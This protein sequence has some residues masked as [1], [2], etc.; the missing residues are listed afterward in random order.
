MLTDDPP[1]KQAYKVSLQPSGLQF[2]TDPAMS[3][4][5][6]A[7]LAQIRLPSSCRNGTCRTCLCKLKS[8]EISYQI[9]WPGLTR[10]EKAEGYLLPC[11]AVAQSDL[12]IDAPDAVSLK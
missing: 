6:S 5:N 4:L 9:D 3:L 12:V 11:V 2:E 8:G 7:L 10:E 1:L